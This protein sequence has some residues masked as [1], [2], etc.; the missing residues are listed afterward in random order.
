MQLE[1]FLTLSGIVDQAIWVDDPKQS[2]YGFRGAEPS[3]MKAVI[4]AVGGVRPEDIQGYNWRSR[5][6]LVYLS[7]ALFTEAFSGLPPEQVALQPIRRATAGDHTANPTDEPPEAGTALVHWHIDFESDRRP[8]GAPW[9]ERALAELLAEWLEEGVYVLPKGKSHWQRAQAG[10]VAV[11]CKSN[12]RCAQVAEALHRAGLRASI[13]RNGLLQTAEAKLILACLRYLLN[14]EDSLSVAELML[15]ASHT[16]LEDIIEQRFDHLETGAQE[17]DWGAKDPFLRKLSALRERTTERSATEL[18]NMLLEEVDLRRK[19]L[20]LGNGRQRLV[21]VE[22]L[23]KLAVD[24]EDRCNRLHA[25]ASLGGFLLW[26]EDLERQGRDMQ[27][28]SEGPDA[29]QVLTYHKSKGLEWPI[30][31]AYD[32]GASLR[33]NSWGMAIVPERETVDLDHVLAHRWL[34][35]WV[36]PY[37]RQVANTPLDQRLRESEIYAGR[38]AEA[39]EEE[40]RLLYVGITRARDYLV[41]P[42]SCK[43]PTRWL[44]RVWQQGQEDAP[45]LDHR[46]GDS[47]WTWEGRILPK[48]TVW[49]RFPADIPARQQADAPA[50]YLERGSGQKTHLPE[51]IQPEELVSGRDFSARVD[52]V[53]QYGEGLALPDGRPA[54]TAGKVIKAYL[55]AFRDDYP[56]AEQLAMASGLIR[57]FGLVEELDARELVELARQWDREQA[58]RF[59]PEWVRRKELV[60]WVK[61][62]RLFER[63][64][65]VLLETAEGEIALI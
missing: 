64:A 6:E 43:E 32:M 47:P 17:S 20:S 46:S 13:A 22:A 14:R 49:R 33:A 40:A 52:Q 23:R 25:A 36:N 9:Q 65:D 7:N 11:L 5:E 18:L 44:N 42:S 54:Y 27:G 63:I 19:V 62:D 16:P 2:I 56:S 41:L 10:D 38:V 31:V 1:I 29:V 8:P 12:K 60:R 39:R 3:L 55:H 48:A 58:Q 28:A 61:G 35:Y 15:L 30:V 53:L 59:R 34:R 24:Y 26:L 51:A 4:E 50:L 45:T 57:D 21:N 37:G